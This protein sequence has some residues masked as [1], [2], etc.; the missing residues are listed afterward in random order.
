MLSR[1]SDRV[2]TVLLAAEGLR[3]KASGIGRVARL[4]ARVLAEQQAQ[5]RVRARALALNDADPIRDLGLPVQ[6]C[7]GSRARFVLE[8]ARA[9]VECTHFLYD[10]TSVARAH[11][12][13]FYPA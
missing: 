6:V 9:A 2:P 8:C 11:P 12:A 13:W 7:S 1:R 3:P 4:T 10:A 5:G